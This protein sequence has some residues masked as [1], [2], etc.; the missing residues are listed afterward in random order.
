MRMARRDRSRTEI[1][2]CLI[3]RAR[4]HYLDREINKLK[5]KCRRKD[6]EHSPPRNLI[7]SPRKPAHVGAKIS[8]KICSS[9]SNSMSAGRATLRRAQTTPTLPRSKK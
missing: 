6:L 5:Q 9:M 4:N 2:D 1:M 3:P 8:Q 7:A